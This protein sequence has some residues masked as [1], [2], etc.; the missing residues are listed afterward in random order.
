M[1]Q[2]SPK[3]VEDLKARE[4]ET[5]KAKSD[6]ELVKYVEDSVAGSAVLSSRGHG[7]NAYDAKCDVAYDEAVRRGKPELYDRGYKRAVRSFGFSA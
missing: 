1:M 7:Y 3:Q 6:E 5:L 2:M 4:A